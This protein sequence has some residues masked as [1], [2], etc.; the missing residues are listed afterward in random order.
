MS[1]VS[2]VTGGWE[3]A[4]E[5]AWDAFRGQTTPVGAV[6]VDAGGAVVAE[7]RGRRYEKAG[8]PGQ[9]RRTAHRAARHPLTQD[10]YSERA[11]CV[12]PSPRVRPPPA[13]APGPALP[14]G[15]ALARGP[16][17]PVVPRWPA[18]REPS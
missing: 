3:R 12:P 1:T 17:W 16:A 7:G 6:V 9:P 18:Q 8:P 5:L 15:P 14:R 2:L 10:Q 4:L 11:Y 13:A